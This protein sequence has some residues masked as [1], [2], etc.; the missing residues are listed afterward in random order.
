MKKVHWIGSSKKDV[1]AFPEEVRR[2]VGFTIWVA[3]TGGKALNAVPLVGF[4]SAKV[5][6][7]VIDDDGNTYRAVYT[8]KLAKAIYVLHAFHKK[9]KKGVATPQKDMDLI[10]T[11]LKAAVEHHRETYEQRQRKSVANDT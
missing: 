9:S 10:R 1:S 11:R 3:Q 6:E 2:E 7:V 5:L 8:V 4:G